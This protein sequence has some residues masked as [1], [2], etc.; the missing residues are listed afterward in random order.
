MVPK[1]SVTAV[2]PGVGGAEAVGQDQGRG[3]VAQHACA[4][5]DEAVDQGHVVQAPGTGPH[6]LHG[7][8]GAD[9]EDRHCAQLR[10]RQRGGCRA[11]RN[12]SG[13]RI[14]ARNGPKKGQHTVVI[15]RSARSAP[16]P[17]T[18]ATSTAVAPSGANRLGLLYPPGVSL[19]RR[20][21]QA[22]TRPIG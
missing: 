14:R 18:T 2:Q 16:V 17:V 5:G 8:D 19:S 7:V 22:E 3:V 10:A 9:H 1:A 12:P 15:S 20:R 6:G 4:R 13:L 11:R 21:R